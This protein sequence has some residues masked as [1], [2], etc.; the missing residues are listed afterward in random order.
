M[1]EEHS[2]G[3]LRSNRPQKESTESAPLL[4]GLDLQSHRFAMGRL[5]EVRTRSEASHIE[6]RPPAFLDN[7]A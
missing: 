4:L 2:W 1:V 3:R 6:L 7:L 5:E